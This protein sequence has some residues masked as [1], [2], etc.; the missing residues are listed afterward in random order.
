MFRKPVRASLLA[1]AV[2]S[3]LAIGCGGDNDGRTTLTVGIAASLTEPFAEIERRY[4]ATH[5]VD[6]V[7]SAA[8][9]NVIERQVVEGAP[10]DLV[11]LAASE[12]MDRL[13]SLGLIRTGSRIDLLGNRLCVVAP[14]ALASKIRSIADLSLPSIERIAIGSPGVPI[15]TYAED[16]LRSYGV[17]D[18]LHL[19]FVYAA[20]VRQ[21]LDYV[22]RGEAECGI[23]YTSDAAMS[24]R[25]RIAF[26]VDSTRH[27]PIRYPAAVVG[28]TR[29]GSTATELLEYLDAA[30]AIFE[31]YG[32][33]P[34]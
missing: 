11:L 5:D 29:G 9:S 31:E 34:L 25:V 14:P 2:S 3:F 13:D 22:E 20:N 28:N 15:R 33:D 4:E 6:I 17:W 21:V 18:R 19:R 27:R 8:A 7:V 24:K 16:A 1:M 23:V 32:F 12:P 26:V 10:F 30:D